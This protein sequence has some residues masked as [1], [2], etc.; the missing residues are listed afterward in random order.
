MRKCKPLTVSRPLIFNSSIVEYQKV[1]CAL[2][3]VGEP[4]RASET[5]KSLLEL[6]GSESLG[7]GRNVLVGG[8]KHRISTLGLVLAEDGK[9]ATS[10]R[11]DRSE[12][13]VGGVD[14]RAQG[15]T[16]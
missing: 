3:Q 2:W 4:V 9:Q 1:R 11:E 8:V 16:P 10:K 14:D 13:W 12:G 7:D 15:E 5:K 6:L